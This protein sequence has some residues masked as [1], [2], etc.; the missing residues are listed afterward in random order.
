MSTLRKPTKSL[1]DCAPVTAKLMKHNVFRRDVD[2]PTLDMEEV[3]IKAEGAP[4]FQLEA[5]PLPSTCYEGDTLDECVEAVGADLDKMC[6]FGWRGDF[7]DGKQRQ[8][9][10]LISRDAVRCWDDASLDKIVNMLHQ[11]KWYGPHLVIA[12]SPPKGEEGVAAAALLEH[13]NVSEVVFTPL[14]VGSQTVVVQL[15]ADC[16]RIVVAQDPIAG[17]M[18]G[19]KVRLSAIIVPQVRADYYGNAGVAVRGF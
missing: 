2:Q 8:L 3:E 5:L 1:F 19:G 14:L 11:M 18:N 15:T 13:E 4:L 7:G 6:L 10:G 12:A 9:R 17:R 16:C